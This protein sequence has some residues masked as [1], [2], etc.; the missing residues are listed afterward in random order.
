MKYFLL[1][2]IPFLLLSSEITVQVL[3]S[4]GPESGDRASASYLVKKDG[5][6]IV[7]IDFGGGAFLRFGQAR[8]KIE[9][10]Q[11]VLLTHLHIDH[12]VELPALIKAGYFSRRKE[13]LNIIGPAGNEYF[14]G[15]N[16]FIQ[17][18]FGPQ[19]A[20]RYMSD[21]LTNESE[22]FPLKTYEVNKN[23]NFDFKELRIT[24]AKVNH[25]IVPAVAYRIQ[26]DD[27][28]IVFSG[29]T[30]AQSEA[31]TVLAKDAD[32]LVAHHAIP[33]HGYEPARRLH[34]QPSRTAHI[35]K[36]AGAKTLLLSHRMTRTFGFEK[37]HQALMSNIYKGKIIWAEDLMEIKLP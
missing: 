5:K 17:L 1:L 30:S 7:L 33:E 13:Q 12:V 4:G 6:A 23:R 14:P 3:G 36:D 29:D 2:F 24:T 22:S 16:E 27:K 32:I 35:A 8:A 20:Y 34:M 26:I 11:V 31:L 19:G 21:I 9:D 37:E 18:Q 15:F 10:L 28:I 25:G